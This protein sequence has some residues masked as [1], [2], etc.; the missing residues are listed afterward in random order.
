M[1]TLPNSIYFHEKDAKTY[2]PL[3]LKC[4]LR[5]QSKA[6]QHEQC[7]H[8]T[9]AGIA[10]GTI[11]HLQCNTVWPWEPQGKHCLPTSGELATHQQCGLSRWGER[12]FQGGGLEQGV[13]P[14]VTL[15]I[16]S[17]PP[18]KATQLTWRLAQKIDKIQNKIQTF[19]I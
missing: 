11:K 15:A 7:E 14:A 3:P 19:K 8:T 6:L 5:T 10:Q 16:G 4:T 17:P 1:Q 18:C 13:G 9:H 12:V 2:V